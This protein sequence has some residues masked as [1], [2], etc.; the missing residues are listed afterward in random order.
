MIVNIVLSNQLKR[1]VVDHD[2]TSGLVVRAFFTDSD[3]ELGAR[4][5]LA[6]V[7]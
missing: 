2:V 5:E 3:P 6:Q 4:F 1:E 7:N